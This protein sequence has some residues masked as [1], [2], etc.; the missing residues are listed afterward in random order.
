MV[1]EKDLHTI[2]S[3][4]RSYKSNL[5]VPPL[6]FFSAVTTLCFKEGKPLN[7]TCQQGNIILLISAT[8]ISSPFFFSVFDFFARLFVIVLP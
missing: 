2:Y 3:T 1:K 8:E 4:S 6:P 5:I 7:L